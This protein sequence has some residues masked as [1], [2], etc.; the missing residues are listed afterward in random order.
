MLWLSSVRLYLI[1]KALEELMK[2]DLE[3]E[4]MEACRLLNRDIL[5]EAKEKARKEERL[6]ERIK[7]HRAEREKNHD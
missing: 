7:K 2:N 4:D 1:S 6:R 3:Q 5:I